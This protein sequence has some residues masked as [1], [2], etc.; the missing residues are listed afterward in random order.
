MKQTTLLLLLLMLIGIMSAEVFTIGDGTSTQ[1]YVP[2]YGLYD[3]SWSKVIYTAAEMNTAGLTA[4]QIDGIG[5]QVGNNPANYVTDDQRVYIRHTTAGLYAAED[6]TLPDNTAFQQ[7]YNTSYT[8]NGG[9]WKYLMFSTPFMW[10]GTSNI[11]IV[12]ENWDG[13]YVSG[14]PNFNYTATTDMMAV[15]KYADGAFPAT[16]T[17]TLYANRPNIQIVTPSVNP[18]GPASL[19]A[20]TNAG[21]A[22]QNT[23]LSWNAGDGMPTSYNLYFGT[24]TTPEFLVNQINTTYAVT[25]LLPGTTY[26]WQVIPQ[27]ANGN[28]SNCPVWSFST[29]AES[30]LAESFEVSVPPAG[31]ASLGTTSWSQST[32]SATDGTYSAYK[33]GSTSNQFTLSTPMLSIAAG[34][35]LTFDLRISTLTGSLDVMYSADRENWTVLQNYMATATNTWENHVVDL[36]AAAGNYYLGFRTS[37]HSASFYLDSVIGPQITPLAPNAPVLDSPDDLAT[38]QSVFPL[39]EWDPAITG[40]VPTSFNV[41]LDTNADPSTLLATT[42]NISFQTVQALNYDTTYYWKVIASNASGDSPASSIFSFTTMS[43]PT[44]STFPWTVDFGTTTSDAF[45]PLN[46]GRMGGQYP[47]TSGTNSYWIRGNWLNGAVGNNDAKINI[48]GTSRYSWLI[49]PPIA[50][51]ADGYELKFDLGLTDYGNSNPIEDTTSQLDDKFIV[52]MSDTPTM[53]NP[54]ILREW[55]NAGSQYVYNAIPNTGSE[56]SIILSGVTGTKYFAFYGESTVSGGDNDLHVD[57]VTVREIPSSPQLAVN[58]VEYDFGSTMIGT[59]ATH[60]FTVSNSG[61]GVLSVGSVVVN[62]TYFSLSEAFSPVQLASGETASIVVQYMPTVVGD[63]TATAVVTA[64]DQEITVNISGTCYDP[65]ISTF[66]WNVDFGTASTDWPVVEWTQLSGLYPTPTGTSVQWMQDDWLNIADPANMAAKI[67]IYGSS[68]YGWL[69]TPPINLPAGNY[70]LSFDAA[71]MEWNASTPPTT[72]QEDDRFIVIVSDS[73][74][75][76]NPSILREWNNTGSQDVLNNIPATGANYTIP[77]TGLSGIKYFAFYGES[78]VTGNGDNDLM[79]DNVNIS[80]GAVENPI[81]AINPT[82]HAFGDVNVGQTASQTFSI[83]NAGTGTLGIQSITISGSDMMSLVNVP[84]LP[85][86]LTGTQTLTFDVNYAPTAAGD[87]SATITITDNINRVAHNVS[88]SG[89]AIQAADLYPPTNLV[90]AVTGND[91]HLSWEAP[92]ETPPPPVGFT[93]DFESYT[94]FSIAFD[95]WT[96]V[97]V[98]QST[99][100]G[101]TNITWPNAYAAMA[102]MIFNPGATTPAVTDLTAHSGAKMAACFASTTPPNNDWMMSPLLEIEN[103]DILRFWAKSYTAQYGLERFKVGV[104]TGGTAPADFTII[105]GTSY[106]SAPVDWTEYTYDMSAYVGQEIRFGIQ[107]ISNDAFIFLVDDVSVGEVP[108]RFA[109]PVHQTDGSGSIARA[110]GIAVP[111]PAQRDVTRDLLGYKV[112]RDGAL[113]ST[114]ASPTTVVYDDVDL[115]VG[116]YAYTV[117]AYYD[118]GESIPAGPANVMITNMVAPLDLAATVDGNDVTLNW[119]SPVPPLEGEWITWCNPEA[120]GNSVGTNSAAEFDVAHMFDATD[121]TAYQGGALAQIKFV[122]AYENCV[123]TVKVWTGGTATEPGTLVYSG[124]HNGFTI[125][126]WNLHILPTPVPIPADR[127]WIGYGVNTQGGYPAGCDDGPVIE[128]KGN[129]MNFGG[130]TT[131]TELAPALTYNWSIQGFVTDGATMKN[132]S[133]K[134][135]A[136]S[137]LST[138][139][140]S[141]SANRFEPSRSNR[142]LLG[143]KVYRDGTQIANISNPEVTTYLDA[144]LDNGQYIYGVSAVYGEGESDPATVYVTVDLQLAP[145]LFGDSFETYPDFSLTFAPWNLLDQDLQ[146]TYGFTG[147]EFP[148]MGSP[149]AYIVFNPTTTTPPIEGLTAQDGTKMIA[150]FAATTPPNKDW[151]ITRRINLGTNS[152]IKFYAKSHT[153]QY[154]LERFRVGVS[155]MATIIPQGFQFISGPEDVQAP[156]EWTEYLYDLSSYDGQSV[157]IAIRCVSN[158]AFVFYVDNVNIHTQGGSVSNDDIS[159]PVAITELKGNYPNPFNPETTIRYSVKE[160]G[161]VAIEIYNLKGQLVKSLVGEDKA[162]GEHSVIWKGTDNN[163]RPVSSGVYFYKM[164]AGQYSSVKKMI[165]MK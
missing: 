116:E 115:A 80:M 63:H 47:N 2:L 67:N 120:L 84:T 46:W 148:N 90:A 70:Q 107:C 50:I 101:M 121:L 3:Y 55:N 22:F 100:Y 138:P 7:V 114:I 136:E 49:T 16:A 96:L 26:Y 5:F 79:I 59:T 54:V 15:Y 12:W 69:V 76:S 124:V 154:G 65:I 130:W 61:S 57:N 132:I 9:G 38:N 127:L 34:N 77:L 157:F 87:H 93:D 18:P 156:T 128:G 140:G 68:R 28:A 1:N 31:W 73:Q 111:V 129:M 21:F 143:Y 150:S 122:P 37:N 32:T 53:A 145:V 92:G 146:P 56:V 43:D 147:V 94:D 45:P 91:V 35:T 153:A 44:I 160:A 109:A 104:S 144:N 98:D 110:T 42:P 139:T 86:G 58:P 106:V 158:D 52:V 102:Y 20:P 64:G 161:P 30:Q 41:Y 95:P 13:T 8:W 118:G 14:Y 4:G 89:T 88:I 66:P 112:Y 99:T 11:E 83:S 131:L 162:A 126:E 82:T 74:D 25:D 142:A 149:M 85:A 17:G 103:G 62:G 159:A 113:I 133:L 123:Y 137:P 78:T 141:L 48:Y 51:P 152:A 164:S 6:N 97:D 165:M 119:S 19:V 40:G 75:M 163:N 39:L 108:V 151:L 29:P 23:T 155:T 117:T 71:L 135:I 33:Y 60:G 72:T 125:G 134:P 24:S 105:S 10:D 81:F 27:N 36:S